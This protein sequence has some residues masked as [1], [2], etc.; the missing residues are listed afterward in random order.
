MAT[1]GSLTT[2][3]DIVGDNST[4]SDE[5]AASSHSHR[6]LPSRTSKVNMCVMCVDVMCVDVS[7]L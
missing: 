3:Y 4:L 5:D 7:P 1:V 6:L 2:C